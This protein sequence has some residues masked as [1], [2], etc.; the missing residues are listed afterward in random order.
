ME[1]ETRGIRNPDTFLNYYT[2]A[3]VV[4]FIEQVLKDI[5]ASGYIGVIEI[6]GHSLRLDIHKMDTESVRSIHSLQVLYLC[7]TELLGFTELTPGGQKVP[8]IVADKSAA[9]DLILAAL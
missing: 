3:G 9:K 6:S 1:V 7:G 5:D 4:L 2:I 8:V